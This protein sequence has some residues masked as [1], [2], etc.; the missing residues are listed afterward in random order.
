MKLALLDQLKKSKAK[1][2]KGV[3][4]LQLPLDN[5]L[6]LRCYTVSFIHNST[7]TASIKL[8]PVR[9]IAYHT[10]VL[11]SS[12]CLF[13]IGRS[14]TLVA[15]EMEFI[16]KN[17]SPYHFLLLLNCSFILRK[18]LDPVLRNSIAIKV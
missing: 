11:L 6:F 1:I 5:I 12:T 7:T 14:R 3:T 17:V 18:A 10:C 15:F 9:T 2:R 4:F 8:L 16:M 13:G